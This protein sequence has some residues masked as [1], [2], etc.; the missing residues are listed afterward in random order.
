MRDHVISR[1]SP[2]E[3]RTLQ[4]TV[5]NTILAA[6]PEPKGFPCS[7]FATPGTFEGYVAR[8]LY[9]HLRGALEEGE[10]PPDLW[11]THPDDIVKVNTAMAVG[12]DDLL[13][14]SKA[15]EA[16]GD[17]VR[18][19]EASWAI[20]KTQGTTSMFLDM[21]F[22]T[23]DLLE[24]ADDKDA[25]KFENEVLI[26]A[27]VYE[28]GSDRSTKAHV[29]SHTLAAKSEASFES[30]VSVGFS[31]FIKALQHLLLLK[32]D[33]DFSSSN[34]IDLKAALD[35]MRNDGRMVR[36]ASALT[37]NASLKNFCKN[38]KLSLCLSAVL[39][40]SYLPEWDPDEYG[41]NE[42]D[43]VGA[44]N[45]YDSSVCAPVLKARYVKMELHRAGFYTISLAL[46]YGNLAAL[47]TWYGKVLAAFEE[48][49]WTLSRKCDFWGVEAWSA[50]WTA[51]PLFIML[52]QNQQACALLKATGHAWNKDGEKHLDHVVT[53]TRNIFPTLKR[54]YELIFVRLL[55]FLSSPDG[56]IDEAEV[57]TWIPSPDVLAEIERDYAYFRFFTISDVTSFGAL[58][59]LRLGR[60][61]DAYELSRITV[62]PE[63]KTMKK[64]TLIQCH[65][66]LGQIAVKRGDLHEADSHFANA[67]EEARLSRLPMLEVLAARDWK[68][69]LLGPKDRECQ[70][71]EVI[72][73]SACVKMKKTREQV[74]SVLRSD[75]SLG[76]V[77]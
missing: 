43:L 40:T 20:A 71:A 56:A 29:R 55:L 75:S 22:R 21:M 59:F 62:S 76:I 44:I 10:D 27:T 2:D 1:H 47:D 13:D 8:Q 41:H 16:A 46:Y 28:L 23:A 57:N 69:H 15:R 35:G 60:D 54:D 45:F 31:S 14:L 68:D 24:R 72:I 64:T 61:S 52:G 51:I 17:L 9:W 32:D 42:V 19:A 11:L 34:E 65:S 36:E 74:A 6:R 26:L 3:L 39:V 33:Y 48:I 66:I 38:C 67:I 53:A 30:Q 5:V 37:E 12:I 70:A 49:D 58:A 18:A 73:D 77:E 25:M 50:Y 7:E 4:E 63:Q